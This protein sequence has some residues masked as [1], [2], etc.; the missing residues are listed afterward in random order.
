MIE[1]VPWQS[2]HELILW[3]RQLQRL[4]CQ[5]G[6]HQAVNLQWKKNLKARRSSHNGCNRKRLIFAE[7]VLVYRFPQLMRIDVAI[8]ITLGSLRGIELMFIVVHI[9][10]P[11]SE[12]C[13]IRA[14]CLTGLSTSLR[15][16]PCHVDSDCVMR[17]CLVNSC[18]V[19]S[20]SG[21]PSEY[22]IDIKYTI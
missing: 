1:D 14:H 17:G 15:G 6:S 11:A 20:N 12:R 2:R 9:W 3:G 16:R 22:L 5:P 19:I 13:K 4:T 8:F 21:Y 18:W 7:L 10:L